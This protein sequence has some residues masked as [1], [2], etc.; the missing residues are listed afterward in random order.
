MTAAAVCAPSFATGCASYGMGASDAAQT[1]ARSPFTSSVDIQRV[2][3][4]NLRANLKA[5]PDLTLL[6]PNTTFVLA[7]DKVVANGKVNVKTLVANL[8][9]RPYG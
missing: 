2:G 9:L 3:M 5:Y 7:D 4:A 6:Q 8:F 1:A